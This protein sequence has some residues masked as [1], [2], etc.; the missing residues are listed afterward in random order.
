MLLDPGRVVAAEALVDSLWERP[1]PSAPKILQAHV[2]ALRKALGAEVI[3]TRAPGYALRGATSDL[4]RFEELAE[5]ARRERDPAARGQA[6]RAALA[7]WRGEPL[8]EFRREPFAAAA[9][10]RLSELRLEALAQRVDAELELGAHEALVGELSTLVAAEPLRERLRAQLM[11]ALYRSGRQADALQVYRDGRAQLV[12]QLGIEPG[13]ELQ[14]L[15]RAILHHD[16][17]VAAPVAREVARRGSVVCLGL[18]PLAL[19]APLGREVLV[20]ELAADA[21]G[22]RDAY[23]RL[24]R[25][26]PGVRTAGFTTAEP[27]D[28]IVRL[29]TEQA[30]ELLVVESAPDALLAAA[31]CDVALTNAIETLKDGAVIVPFGGAPGEWPALELGAWVA[32]AHGRPLR[33]LGVEAGGGRRDASRALAGASLALQRFA[34]ITAETALVVPGPA[35]VLGAGGAVVVASLP[36]GELDATRRALLAADVPVL[37]VH[38]GLKPSGLAPDRTMTRFSWSLGS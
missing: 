33:L 15:E 28:D 17:A 31:P 7:L 38:G 29:A 3:E 9:A 19:L 37:L 13:P 25:L 2:S 10:A 32:R 11:L 12:E 20:V 30:A 34:G 16:T 5:G 8:A 26:G 36:R 24:A 6:L 14:G 22:L 18:A 27:V 4:A 21:A 1:P 35:G 23:R